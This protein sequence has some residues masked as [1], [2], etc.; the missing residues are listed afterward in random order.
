MRAMVLPGLVLYLY[1][2]VF[3][4]LSPPGIN[5][6]F[7]AEIVTRWLGILVAAGLIV[8]LKTSKYA[9]DAVG[10]ARSK[11]DLFLVLL[12]LAPIVQY[13]VLNQD[14][15]SLSDSLLLVMAFALAIY[16]LVIEV[17]CRLRMFLDCRVLRS[18]T[19]ALLFVTLNM[20]AFAGVFAW[21]LRGDGQI[22]SLLLLAVS[23]LCVLLYVKERQMLS[24]LCVCLFV[25]TS[26]QAM[27]QGQGVE[28]AVTSAE[29]QTTLVTTKPATTP[30]IYLLTYDGYVENQTMLQYGID[31]SAQENWLQERG[32][33]IYRGTY[34]AGPES[35]TSMG[36][37][38][39]EEEHMRKATAGQNRVIS[40]LRHAGYS[41][42]GIF[43]NDYFFQGVG[44]GYDESYPRPGS[45]T[46]LLGMAVFE[47]EFRHNAHFD[48]P[49]HDQFV[50]KKRGLMVQPGQRPLF[51]YTHTGPG[52]SQN[53]GQCLDD[54][55][56]R[57]R[58]RLDAANL[59]MRSDITTLL[60]T[61][62]KKIVIINGDHGPYLTKNCHG[63]SRL[64]YALSDVSRLDIQDRYGS[65]L[66]VRWPDAHGSRVKIDQLQ[67]LMPA[68][69]SVLYPNNP[70]PEFPK[71]R[72]VYDA[73]RATAGVTV[74]DGVFDNGRHAGERLFDSGAP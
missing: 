6:T 48:K 58:V 59:E 73:D 64:D 7:V 23:G 15:L 54:E 72:T 45:A 20:A 29:A 36:R 32:F 47:G 21:H 67:D 26:A 42:A 35:I 52:H 65:F 25:L 16:L 68:V 1:A 55:I 17:P 66:A 33:R 50:A 71:F 40:Q 19:L 9:A 22:Q 57:F 60:S 46:F 5:G 43:P 41:T 12:P 28:N 11:S 53:S 37:V 24:W 18:L 63:L 27:L 30:D 38:F 8:V 69:L 70:L 56:E 14:I 51:M 13:T 10:P 62:R 39:G 4:E 3:D 61:A 31:N 2:W 44:G 34:T 49:D 74:T